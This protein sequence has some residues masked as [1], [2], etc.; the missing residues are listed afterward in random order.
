MPL[1]RVYRFNQE[2]QRNYSPEEFSRRE[3]EAEPFLMFQALGGASASP[4]F[5]SGEIAA[6]WHQV[7][8]RAISELGVTDPS[9]I[10]D[11]VENQRRLAFGLDPLPTQAM[12]K[13]GSLPQPTD[14]SFLG[15]VP[16]PP[17][18]PEAEGSFL[19]GGEGE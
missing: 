6:F 9:V 7:Y 11:W 18:G 8:N 17:A 12:D 3:E 15:S 2:N 4:S 13:T 5:L 16:P 1:S 19:G 14:T 10:D